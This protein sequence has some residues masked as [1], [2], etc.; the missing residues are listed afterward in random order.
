M[1]WQLSSLYPREHALGTHRKRAFASPHVPDT[2]S[3]LG[4]SPSVLM[5][6]CFQWLRTPTIK[7]NA[8]AGLEAFFIKKSL[9]LCFLKFRKLYFWRA[10]ISSIYSPGCW[11]PCPGVLMCSH[12]ITINSIV[13]EFVCYSSAPGMHHYI[14]NRLFAASCFL[15]FCRWVLWTSL[16]LYDA[17]IPF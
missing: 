15:S 8:I 6:G 10:Q 16:C 9:N 4:H 13:G 11:V 5:S 12:S 14:E 1:T 7:A 2:L 3:D 17:I